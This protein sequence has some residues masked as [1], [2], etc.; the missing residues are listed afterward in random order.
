MLTLMPPQD[1]QLT[2]E[3]S[4]FMETGRYAEAVAFCRRLDDASPNAK[5]IRYGTSGEGRP[6]IALL[7]SRGQEKGSTKPLILVING[8][9]AG[10]LE[11]KDA[12]LILARRILINKKD[13]HVIDL[14]LIHI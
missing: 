3:K 2:Y 8:I 5:V 4:R 11:G 9:H 1:W 14:S 10:E 12:N 13:Q 7:I 6:M